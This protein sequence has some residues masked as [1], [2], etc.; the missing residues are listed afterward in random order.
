MSDGKSLEHQGVI[1]DDIVLPTGQDM[2][3]GR[4]PALVRA[5]EVLGV[6]ITPE[7]AGKAFPYEWLPE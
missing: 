4:D 5:A 7:E 2:A 3:S 6:K 1:P